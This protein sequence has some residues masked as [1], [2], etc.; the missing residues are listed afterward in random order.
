LVSGTKM[1]RAARSSLGVVIS[2]IGQ[3]SRF[4]SRP[5][6]YARS[7]RAAS[8]GR[9]A[10]ATRASSALG[11][12]RVHGRCRRWRRSSSRRRVRGVGGAGGSGRARRDRT[13]AGPCQALGGVGLGLAL[14]SLLPEFGGGSGKADAE[15]GGAHP[16]GQLRPVAESRDDRLVHGARLPRGCYD[17]LAAVTTGISEAGCAVGRLPRRARRARRPRRPT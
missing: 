15:L 12:R 9:R 1:M 6:R 16:R 3:S 14:E 8:V 13:A 2:T 11:S 4:S 10:A 7:G 17:R 5:R